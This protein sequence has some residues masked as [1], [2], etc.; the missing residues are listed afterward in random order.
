MVDQRT[1]KKFLQENQG[2]FFSA[3]EL[4]KVHDENVRSVFSKMAQL[5]NDSDIITRQLQVGGKV[6]VITTY[7]FQEGSKGFGNSIA[8]YH[9]VRNRPESRNMNTQTVE[10]MLIMSKLDEIISLL[11]EG[12]NHGNKH[13]V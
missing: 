12:I 7:S 13:E 2:T 5:K 8:E 1:L 4:S 6:G 11:K 3:L 9:S 10:N